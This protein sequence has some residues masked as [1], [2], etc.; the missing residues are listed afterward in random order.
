M[1]TK[2]AIETAAHDSISALEPEV[3]LDLHRRMVRIRLFEEE[4]GKLM[5]AGRMPGFLH[6]YVGQEAVAAGFAVGPA[7]PGA[8]DWLIPQVGLAAA[9]GGTPAALAVIAA[10]LLASYTSFAGA[11]LALSR[12][13]QVLAGQG[14]FLDDIRLQRDPSAG[15]AAARSA[16]VIVER[17][18]KMSGFTD[19]RERSA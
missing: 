8:V 9:A 6:L 7:P 16:L 19:D 12:L 18:Y 15:L 1:L 11:L 4:A 5:E 2:P 17:I 14:V 10:C 13:T 3:L